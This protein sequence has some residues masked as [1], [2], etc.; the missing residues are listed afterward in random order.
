MTPL[1]DKLKNIEWGEYKLGDLFEI[2]PT[3]YYR[4]KN[5]QIISTDGSVPLI[6]N[7]STDNGVMGFSNLKANNIGNTL[8]CSD[9]TMGA[10]TMFYQEKDFIGYSHIQH[11][12][13]KFNPFNKLIA[14]AIISASRVTTSE[15]Y[16]YGNKFNR[17]A[18]NKTKIQLPTKNGKIDFDFIESFVAKLENEH[19][20][21]LEN[22]IN[23]IGLSDYHLT[24]QQKEALENFESG[25]IKLKEY[26]IGDLFTINTYKKRFDANKV[27]ITDKGEPYVVRTSINNGVRGYIDEDKQFLNEGNTISFGQDTATVYY[28]EQPY[29]TGDKIKIV[30]AKDSFFN[31]KNAFY[32][33]ASMTKSFSSFSWGGSSFSVKIIKEQPIQIPIKENKPDYETMETIISAIH[34]LVIKDVVLYV[35]RKKK[36]LN[37]LTENANA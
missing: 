23:E 21:K 9:T 37:K 33:I 15:K 27:N 25:K 10:E 18:M 29:F 4:L 20:L 22:Y 11:L 34:K 26:K 28:Q 2:N 13:P 3:K 32:F 5:E 35:E 19:I 12:V 1:N 16:D 7:S 36:E 17:V 8:T 14:Y 24:E 6:S 31:R 30:K